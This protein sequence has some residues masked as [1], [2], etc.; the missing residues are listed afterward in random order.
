MSSTLSCA[1]P[2]GIQDDWQQIK[3]DI[4]TYIEKRGYQSA[5]DLVSAI[6]ECVNRGAMAL[7]DG[8]E[9][10]HLYEDLRVSVDVLEAAIQGLDLRFNN[11][12]HKSSEQ[13]RKEAIGK[14]KF[15][16][17]KITS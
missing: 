5:S 11:E 3:N 13:T 2:S 12:Y 7:P 17:N 1:K 6:A 9:N 10:E 14:F 15:W 4:S 16:A 8:E